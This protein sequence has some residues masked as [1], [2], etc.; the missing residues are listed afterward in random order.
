MIPARVIG[1]MVLNQTLPAFQGVPFLLVEPINEKMITS[2]DYMVVCDAIGAN[3]GE[4]VF[5]AQGRE[6]TFNLPDPFNPADMTIIAII[7]QITTGQ[8]SQKE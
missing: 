7:D 2:G 1:R 5:L 6:A 3:L 4:T 8:D